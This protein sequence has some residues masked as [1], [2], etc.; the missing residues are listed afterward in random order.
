MRRINSGRKGSR[1][2]GS[3]L[4]M[5]AIGM[6]T[7]LLATGLCVDISHFYLVKTELQNA[8]DAAALAG[9]SALNSSELGITK[10]R[11]RAGETMNRYEFNH[12]GI[13]VPPANVTFAVNLDGPYMDETSAKAQAKKIRFVRVSTPA[14]PVKVFFAA[15]VLGGEQELVA[16]ATAGMSVPLTSVCDFLPVSVI[17]YGTPITAGSVYTFRSA[18]SGTV[19][20]GNYQ[21]LA[22]AG[23]G[24]QDVRIGIASGVDACASPGEEYAVDT[25]TG[26][27]AGPVRVGVNTRFDEYGPQVDPATQPPDTNV[28]ENIIYDDYKEG[29]Q[30]Q[31]PTHPGVDGRRIVIIPIV[32]QSEYDPGRNVVRFNRF[33]LFFLRKK[34]G[35]GS[36]GEL[37][38]EYIDD[39][40]VVGR[41]GVGGGTAAANGL[42]AKPVLYQ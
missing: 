27:T 6:L 3:V 4:A 38:A 30:T 23:Q 9:A 8:A 19:S 25:K 39:P 18:P 17:D 40:T 22:V 36:G 31:A 12:T 37:E 7:F 1:E 13:T 42:L 28:K 16:E 29:R 5:S 33:G 15:S 14:S 10:A 20:P 41:G 2:R 32:L 34:V 21:L 35:G 26:V 24:G 11:Q